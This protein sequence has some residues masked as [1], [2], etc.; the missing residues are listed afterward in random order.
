MLRSE[1]DQHPLWVTTQQIAATAALVRAE[2]EPAEVPKLETILFYVSHAESFQEIATT[3]SALF[4]GEMLEAVNVPFT[5]AANSLQFRL[6]NGAAQTAHL[7]VAAAQAE[8]SL[9]PMGPWPRPYGKGGQV[10]QMNTLFEGLLESQRLSVEA[11]RGAHTD[12]RE[13]V[14][15]FEAKAAERQL[16]LESSLARMQAEGESVTEMVTAEKA[17][18]DQVVAN[19]LSAVGAIETANTERYKAWKAEQEAKFVADFAPLQVDIRARL[20][21]SEE[22][23]EKLRSTNEQFENL[24]AIAAGETIANNFEKEAS[25]GRTTGIAMYS[26]G[27][28]FLLAAAVPLV[29]LL[30]EAGL[31]VNGTPQWGLITVRL[32]IGILAG[33]AATVIIRLGARL[34]SNANASKRMELEL[35]SIG[36]F[37]ANVVEPTDVDKARIALVT[38]AFG[39]IS[40]DTPGDGKDESVSVTSIA[41]ILELVMKAMK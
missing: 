29:W 31:D 7:D 9:I 32:A 1:F 36:P 22:V 39:Q 41:Q 16:V 5:A 11:L 21:A 17:R 38:R 18:I 34:I 27:G 30:F 14:T 33:S 6:A 8:A 28:A 12:L 10:T 25:W 19:G 4:S 40:G 24:S 35:R 3:S 15:S 13:E 37:L 23:Y 20:A 26:V 2:Q